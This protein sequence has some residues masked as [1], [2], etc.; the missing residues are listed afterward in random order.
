MSD[1]NMRAFVAAT[2]A[3]ANEIGDLDDSRFPPASDLAEVALE[4]VADILL[5]Q[6]RQQGIRE[7]QAAIDNAGGALDPLSDRSWVRYALRA[8]ASLLPAS[9]VVSVNGPLS[10]DE[11]S[12][13]DTKW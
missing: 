12:S 8:V 13:M 11:E 9:P 3:I 10:T 7:A 6:G 2:K 5:E 4:A 1:L